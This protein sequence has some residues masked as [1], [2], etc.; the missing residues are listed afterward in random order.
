L[1]IDASVKPQRQ[2]LRKMSDEKV[3]AV[4]SEVQRL[5]DASHV[6]QMASEHYACQKEEWEVE[7]VH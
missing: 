4:K 3:V 5:L 2:K 1:N 6:Y 7:D